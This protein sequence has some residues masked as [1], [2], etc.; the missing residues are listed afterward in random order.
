MR[1][2]GQYPYTLINGE[3]ETKEKRRN[4]DI[5]AYHLEGNLFGDFGRGGELSFKAYYFDS[6]RGLPGSVNLYNKNTS[7]RLWDN[8]FSCN[9]GIRM[10]LMRNLRYGP[11]LSIIMLLLVI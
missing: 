3:L 2:D 9:R 4:S 6:E 10:F 8:N 7:E 5:H 11:W 1:A